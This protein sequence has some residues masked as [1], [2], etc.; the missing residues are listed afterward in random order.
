MLSVISWNNINFFPA[1]GTNF[2]KD[3]NKVVDGPNAE[4]GELGTSVA[5]SDDN[6]DAETGME[7]EEAYCGL[8]HS[9]PGEDEGGD[10]GGHDDGMDQGEG[11]QPQG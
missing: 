7:D 1:L 5:D 10:G 3:G 6:A 4:V 9:F 11:Y 8:S 2:V